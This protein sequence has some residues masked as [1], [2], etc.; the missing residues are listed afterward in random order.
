VIAVTIGQHRSP[1]SALSEKLLRDGDFLRLWFANSIS[2]AGTMVTSVALPALMYRQT[3]SAALTSLLGAAV[4]GPYLLFGVVAGVMADRGDRRRIMVRCNM[5]N[6]LLTA[7]IPLV[8]LVAVP[9]PWQL[10][11]V[12]WG[13]GSLRVWFEAANF[14][15]LPALVPAARLMEANSRIWSAVTAAQIIVPGVAGLLIATIGS[16]ASIAL[17]AAS[18]AVAAALLSLIRRPLNPARPTMPNARRNPVAEARDG[19][20]FLV[21]EPILR[22]LTVLCTANLFA[23]GALIGLLVVY[24]DDH[25]GIGQTDSRLGLFFAA[26]G[27]GALFATLLLPYL[28][29]RIRP[30][31]LYAVAGCL[32]ALVLLGIA[33]TTVWWLSLALLAVFGL[34]YMVINVGTLTI[35]QALTPGHLQGR[36]NMIARV[37]VFGVGYSSGAIIGGGLAEQLSVSL[38]LVLCAVPLALTTIVVATAGRRDLNVGLG[39]K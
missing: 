20:R 37:I 30:L 14:G 36:V 24:A 3:G 13:V 19:L 6:A 2:V 34:P 8:A 11:V 22:L 4:T 16:T 1:N 28:N 29:R 23:G 35:R 17:D 26:Q 9:P 12:A 39:N 32:E 33:L 21:T 15:A 27:M 38:S 31:V 25:F 7:S 5:A 18:F 10:L